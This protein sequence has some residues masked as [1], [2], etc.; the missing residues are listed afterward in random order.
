VG[1]TRMYHPYFRGKQYELITV[2]EMAPL[3]AASSF[4]PIIEPVKEALGGLERTL[5]AVCNADG[6]AIV[7]INPHHGVHAEDG[8]NISVLLQRGFSENKGIAAGVLLKKN[9][10]VGEAIACCKD[11]EGHELTLIHAGFTDA[12]GLAERLG[13]K[14]KEMRHVF[15]EEECG[16]L[17]RKHFAG[18]DRILL[19]D[20]FERRR[21]RDHPLL[22]LF[23]DLH[24]TYPEEGM[25]GFGDFLFVGDDYSE[26]GGPAY[27]VAIHLTFIDPTKDDAMYIYHFVSRRKDT[28]TDPA[29]KFAEALGLMMQKLQQSDHHIFESSA[30]Q[31][32][33]ELHA[34]GHFPG[35]G[36]VKKLSM[37]HHIE[38][39][40][41]FMD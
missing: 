5:R 24:V 8:E 2:R 28:P 7:I 21:N 26:S 22:E 11:H 29:G 20:G 19:R 10:S 30:V 15:F 6:R 23:S 27:A 4:V 14:I 40:A 34:R 32:F 12:K 36:Y 16:K 25:G 9:M 39:L 13:G 31:E 33:R 18:A 41:D 3:L 38:T 1:V 37:K 35:L 17:Y